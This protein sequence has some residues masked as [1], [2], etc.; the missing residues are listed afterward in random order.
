MSAIEQKKPLPIDPQFIDSQQLSDLNKISAFSTAELSTLKR[1]AFDSSTSL[2]HLFEEFVPAVGRLAFEKRDTLFSF[3]REKFQEVLKKAQDDCY[4]GPTINE[5]YKKAVTAFNERVLPEEAHL[6]STKELLGGGEE[7]AQSIFRDERL[8]RYCQAFRPTPRETLHGKENDQNALKKGSQV[9]KIEGVKD[10][11]D[12]FFTL[13]A[14]NILNN[15]YRVAE[16]KVVVVYGPYCLSSEDGSETLKT[17]ALLAT[18]KVENGNQVRLLM[19]NGPEIFYPTIERFY[20]TLDL[21]AGNLQ[22]PSLKL[23]KVK[24]ATVTSSPPKKR[25]FSGKQKALAALI[26]FFLFILIFKPHTFLKKW[27]KKSPEPPNPPS[28]AL[29]P[30]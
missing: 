9:K 21:C 10:L 20:Q 25:S 24:A 23:P 22:D 13:K 4:K 11:S 12:T 19:G 2:I 5:L 15:N 30:L 14:R 27:F 6:P 28:Q 26:G 16:K 18:F 3:D 7:T 1:I 17:L 29:L 8:R